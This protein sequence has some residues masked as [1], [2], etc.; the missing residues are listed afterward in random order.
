MFFRGDFGTPKHSG[1]TTL[2]RLPQKMHIFHL[3]NTQE[4]EEELICE[5]FAKRWIFVLSLMLQQA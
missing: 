4:E 5:F 1:S 2:P 3:I